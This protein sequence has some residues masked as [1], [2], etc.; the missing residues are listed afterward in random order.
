MSSCTS[1]KQPLG[2]VECSPE[3]VTLRLEVR[4]LRREAGQA[5]P[6]AEALRKRVKDLQERLDAIEASAQEMDKK[7]MPAYNE[8]LSWQKPEKTQCV[9]R[10]GCAISE[11]LKA[12][13][14]G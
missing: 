3:V 4:K 12:H 10:I 2:C 6:D 5:L 9:F 7:V 11:F 1:C 8:V 13:F 14:D